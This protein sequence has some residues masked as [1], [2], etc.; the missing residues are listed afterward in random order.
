MKPRGEPTHGITKSVKNGSV[1]VVTLKDHK[2]NRNETLVYVTGEGWEKW[3]PA[4]A[5]RS[6]VAA[7]A[8]AVAKR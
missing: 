4:D 7:R 1:H 3:E 5:H 6:K 2:L 8:P